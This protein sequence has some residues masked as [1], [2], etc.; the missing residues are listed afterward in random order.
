MDRLSETLF[1]GSFRNMVEI[2]LAVAYVV[3]MFAVIAFR[4][5][6]IG[7]RDLFRRS[8]ILF[9]LY[10]ILPA[11]GHGILSLATAALEPTPSAAADL[12]F[13]P[14]RGVRA[15]NTIVS[16]LA[17]CLLAV[18]ICL[19]LGSLTFRGSDQSAPPAEK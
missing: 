3:C 10:L 17:T 9:G 15:G 13:T 16:V 11:I 7:D 19:G 14:N 1:G 8:Y 18:S 4:P 5:Q 2:N 6:R 12:L